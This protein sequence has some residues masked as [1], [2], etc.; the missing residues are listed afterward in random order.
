[1]LAWTNLTGQ[2]AVAEGEARTIADRRGGALDVIVGQPDDALSPSKVAVPRQLAIAS[3]LNWIAFGDSITRGY[4]I[5]RGKPVID[6]GYPATLQTRLRGVLGGGARVL[7]LGNGGENTIG[8]LARIRRTIPSTAGDA[9]II[10]EGTNDVSRKHDPGLVAFNLQRMAEHTIGAGLTTFLA[11]VPPFDERRFGGP[12]NARVKQVNQRI[13]AIASAAGAQFVNTHAPL[14]GRGR[15]FVDPKHPSPA[16]Y[17][18][19]GDIMF[20]AIRGNGSGNGDGGGGD[21]D[22]DPGAAVPGQPTLISPVETISDRSPTYIWNQVA[23]MTKYRLFV[24]TSTGAAISNK[25]YKSRKVCSRGECRVSLRSSLSNG[26][27]RWSVR[28]ENKRGNGGWSLSDFSV[29]AAV[30]DPDPD[31]DP[32]AGAPGQPTPTSPVGTISDRDP[33]YTWNQVANT[34]KYRVAVFPSAGKAISNKLY[35]SKKVCSTGV[36]RVRQKS[37]LPAGD[38]RWFVRGQN[39]SGDGP[40]SLSSE[41]AV[42]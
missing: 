29:N 24:V 25:L 20:H 8:G 32:V 17:R 28:G 26:D 42:E 34:E 38:Y 12:N 19:I 18:V 10:M 3:E 36:C 13:V 39:D 9:V 21:P 15:L 33:I 14:V 37:G 6:P 5:V 22:P 7:N 40:W 30:A 16:G 23:N 35:K 1:M 31:L 11:A 27:Y 4:T 41:F 2:L